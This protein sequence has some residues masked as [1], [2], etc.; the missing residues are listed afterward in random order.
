[1]L[2]SGHIIS[3]CVKFVK[4]LPDPGLDFSNLATVLNL[5][6]KGIPGGNHSHSSGQPPFDA[7][8]PVPLSQRGGFSEEEIVSGCTG[9]NTYQST[10]A[11]TLSHP[12]RYR[13]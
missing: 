13:T 8:N 2:L 7:Y 9:M 12:A 1:M 4:D 10:S 3:I 6:K 5:R 11:A